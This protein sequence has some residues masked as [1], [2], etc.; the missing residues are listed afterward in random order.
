M[1]LHDLHIAHR[2]KTYLHDLHRDSERV[3]LLRHTRGRRSLRYL[4]VMTL[5]AISER[6]EAGLDERYSS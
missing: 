2:S 6:L 4:L 3:R 1:Q 5:R